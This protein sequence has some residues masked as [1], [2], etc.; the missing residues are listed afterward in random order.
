[1][2][3]ILMEVHSQIDFFQNFFNNSSDDDDVFEGL[4]PK[5]QMIKLHSRIF[6]SPV[7]LSLKMMMMIV[8]LPLPW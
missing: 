1:M 8:S 6:L 7:V 2:S 5:L 4:R 3:R